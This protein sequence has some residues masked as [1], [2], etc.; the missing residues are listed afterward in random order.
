MIGFMMGSRFGFA[1]YSNVQVKA[2]MIPNP[3]IFRDD[4]PL[5]DVLNLSLS[6]KDSEFQEDIALINVDGNLLGLIDIQTLAKLQSR[7]VQEQLAQ[8][9]LQQEELRQQNLALFQI[10]HE[11]RQSQGRYQSLFDNN[12]FGVALLTPDG[13][14]HAINHR[15][16]EQLGLPEDY[17]GRKLALFE[18]IDSTERRAFRGNLRQHESTPS[19]TRPITQEFHIDT[20][21]RGRRIFEIVTRW[22]RETGQICACFDDITERRA[23]ER[24]LARQEKQSLLDTL[25]GG[26]AH[27]LN[28]KITPVVGFADL[29]KGTGIGRNAHFAKL[30][31]QSAM[32]AANIIQQLLQLS[33]PSTGRVRK[34]DLRSIV[35]ES[36]AVLRFKLRE[37]RCELE[38]RLPNDP[39][40][41]LADPPQLKQ[42]LMNLALNALH[43]VRKVSYPRLI[44][45]ASKT[46]D[47][48][49]LAVYDNGEGISEENLNRI[50]DPF[51]TTKGP[52]EGTGLGLSVCFSIVNQHNGLISAQSELGEGATFIVKIPIDT[53]P[54]IIEA[55]D[56]EETAGMPTSQKL[57]PNARVLIVDDEESIR[58]LLQEFLR[59]L[60]GCSVDIASTGVE[61]VALLEQGSY[62]LVISD[63]RMPNMGGLE[64]YNWIENNRPALANRFIFITGHAGGASSQLKMEQNGVPVVAKPFSPSQLQEICGPYLR[65]KTIAGNERADAT[66]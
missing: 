41:I 60:F 12:G 14:A 46:G 23:M 44:I 58:L 38:L 47:A 52:D 56:P 66:A 1:L 48:A 24:H 37:A 21:E 17:D 62:N 36:V 31:H 26:I 20:P 22:I 35:E 43:A 34:V 27:E 40:P 53:S 30:I 33:K 18:L 11:L 15:L 59:E 6:R 65:S 9:Q 4:I 50:F 55:I 7:M 10:N 54:A 28:N 64:L 42:V 29:I 25:V 2:A 51:F 16:K 39:I 3:L 61:A 8:L 19:S 45:A 5:R 32:E 63:V 57:V 13:S 49:Q